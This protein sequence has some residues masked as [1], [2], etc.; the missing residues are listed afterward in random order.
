MSQN[1]VVPSS[2]AESHAATW[3]NKDKDMAEV[4]KQQWS[5]SPGKLQPV[6]LVYC[7]CQQ[8]QACGIK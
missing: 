6:L 5:K 1:H 3:S 7:C 8:Q 2:V 4:D